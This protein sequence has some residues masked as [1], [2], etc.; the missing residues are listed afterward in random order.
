MLGC[1]CLVIKY[2]PTRVSKVGRISC[3]GVVDASSEVIG[4]GFM[5]GDEVVI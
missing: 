3:K 4:K 2:R 1:I 5:D